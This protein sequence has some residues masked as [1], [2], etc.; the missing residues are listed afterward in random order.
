MNKNVIALRKGFVVVPKGAG[1][2]QPRVAQLV[3]SVQAELMNLGYMLSEEAYTAL[4]K[5]TQNFIIT[6]HDEV[7]DYLTDMLGNKHAYRAFY[8]NFPKQVMEMSDVELFLNAVCHYWSGGVWE[9]AQEALPRGIKFERTKFTTLK[10]ANERTFMKIFTNLV[11]INQALTPDDR[12]IVAWFTT[13]CRD[14]LEL[15]AQIPFKETL[16]LLASKGIDVPVSTPTDVLRIAVGLGG[17]DISLPNVP[18]ASKVK[19][20]SGWGSW[21][22]NAIL[23]ANTAARESFKFGKFKRAQRRFIMNFF[24][25]SNLDLGEMQ[26]RL[27]RF[28]RLGERLHV[29]E[30]S[31]THPK[32]YAAFKHLREQEE[33]GKIRTFEAR[34]EMAFAKGGLSDGMKV[35][36][37]RPGMFARR[38]DWMLRTYGAGTTKILNQFTRVASGVS[39]KVL[40]ELYKHFEGRDTSAPRT[41]MLK[42]KSKMQTLPDLPALPAAIIKDVQATIL[43]VISNGFKKQTPLG[44]VWIDTSP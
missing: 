20:A 10:L 35:L 12:E 3:A 7:I 44:K 8:I 31:K 32:T 15:P 22:N 9:P 37:E 28:L 43:H 42:A 1:Q 2:P 19:V 36:A 39:L 24:E 29:G 5:A 38:L 13:N 40:F 34:V 18:K 25:K 41:I 30:F 4:S 16:C 33:L 14:S 17:G 27:G 21:R 11:S 26:Q 23:A 6:F